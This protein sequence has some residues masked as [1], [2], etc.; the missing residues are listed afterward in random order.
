MNKD[1]YELTNLRI[2][3]LESMRNQIRKSVNP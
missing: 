3:E 1:I 2:D